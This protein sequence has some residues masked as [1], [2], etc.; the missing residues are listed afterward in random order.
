MA[1]IKIRTSTTR[2]CVN[3]DLY[4]RNAFGPLYRQCN[5]QWRQARQTLPQ[6]IN[7]RSRFIARSLTPTR[8]DNAHL[9]YGLIWPRSLY[10]Y[11]P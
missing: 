5:S 9:L 8:A 11:R 6:L 2:S 7:T 4:R 10:D 3:K 1:P